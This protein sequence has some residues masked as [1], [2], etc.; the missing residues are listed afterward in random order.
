MNSGNVQMRE[1]ILPAIIV[2]ICTLVS[3][4]LRSH[5]AATN[6][7]MVYFV[8]VLIVATRFSRRAAMLSSFFSVAAFDFFC[9]PPYYTFVVAQSEY[10]I[11]FAVMLVVALLISAMTA[12]IRLQ[13]AA[14][15]ERE[16]QTN[17]LYRLSN[18]LAGHNRIFEIAKAAAGL[19]EQTFRLKVS[20]FLPGP[21][22]KISF[23]RRT[24]DQLYVPSVEQAIAEW[25]FV[26]GRNAGKGVNTLPGASALY[27]PVKSAD[28][29][30]AVMAV[31]PNAAAEEALMP[32]RQQLLEVFASHT[33]VAIERAIAASTAQ[34]AEVRIETESMRTSLLSAVSHDLR[35]PLASITGA[36]GTLQTHWDRLDRPM[37]DE[38]LQSVADEADRLN[39]LLNNLLEVTRLE[40]GVRLHKESFPLEEVVGAALHRLKGQLSG[41]QVRTDIPADLPMVAIDDVLMEQVFIN[42]LENALKYT[43]A[44]SDIEVAARQRD[45]FVDVEV[46]DSGPGFHHGDEDRIFDKFFRGRTDNSRGAGLG[47][48]ICRAI[49][50][51]H[52]GTIWA[53]NRVGGGAIIL[54]S[55]PAS[56]SERALL[57]AEGSTR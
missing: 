3:L 41:W 26:N 31:V 13:T 46:R 10:L 9:V 14:A 32:E 7:V 49:I 2:G 1:Y 5:L 15:V 43:P 53:Q 25:V 56:D 8:G 33:G 22:G 16:T 42:V 24:S 20:I 39:R 36:A 11:T 17:A 40:S 45:G 37:R 50:E 44:G 52:G 29:N 12:Q 6:L 30:L 47:L 18:E 4:L 54:F 23:S 55:I 27:I 21:D 48:A 19:A 34:T 35:T 57:R 51:A 28:K 38:L